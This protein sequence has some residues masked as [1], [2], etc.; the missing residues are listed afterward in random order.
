[1][2][3]LEQQGY[4]VTYIASEDLHTNGAQLKNHKVFISGAHDEYWSKEMFDAA[5]AARNSRHLAVLL[6]GQRRLLAGALR[7]RPSVG[8]A[9][10]R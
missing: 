5:I 10:P 2:S 1:M 9:E 8:R 6:R 7:G 4:D 3:W